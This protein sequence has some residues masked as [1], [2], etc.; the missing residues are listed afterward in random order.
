MSVM[1]G[2]LAQ[3]PMLLRWPAE[4]AIAVTTSLGAAW[5]VA[6]FCRKKSAALRAYLWLLGY[7]AA[8]IWMG[9]R[10][11]GATIPLA[12]LPAEPPPVT[13]S[14]LL[15]P[16]T[17]KPEPALEIVPPPVLRID[18]PDSPRSTEELPDSSI[19]KPSMHIDW[20]RWIGVVWVLGA[21]FVTLRVLAGMGMLAR[22]L[23]AAIPVPAESALAERLAL[24]GSNDDPRLQIRMHSTVP[25][26]VSFG[27]RKWWVLLPMAAEHW[28]ATRLR[29]VLAHERAHCE[30]RDYLAVLLLRLFSAACWF[31]P[32]TWL[33]LRRFRALCENAA[34]DRALEQVEAPIYARELLSIVSELRESASLW[35]AASLSIG[36][37]ATVRQRIAAMLDSARDRRRPTYRTS[38]A[39]SI[40]AI[41]AA[42]LVSGLRLVH[43]ENVPSNTASPASS[44]QSAPKT[45]VRP[46]IKEVVVTVQ[47]DKGAAIAGA[48]IEPSTTYA[49]FPPTQWFDWN[50]AVPRDSVTTDAAGRAVL[51]IPAYASEERATGL[52]DVTVTHPDYCPART[53]IDLAAITPLTLQRGGVIVVRAEAE[54]GWFVCADLDSDHYVFNVK[55]RPKG[56]P[57]SVEGRVPPGQ[58]TIR[59]AALGPDGKR[60]FSEVV[61]LEVREGVNQEI[62]LPLARSTAV[63]GRL[64]ADVPRP[65]R[66]GRVLG[67][68]ARGAAD[69][70]QMPWLCWAPVQPDGTFELTNVPRGH[71]ELVVLCNGYV[72]RNPFWE[73]EGMNDSVR[74][75]RFFF[76][77]ADDIEV[78]MEKTGAG[79][80]TVLTSEGKPLRDAMV[81]IP[82]YQDMGRIGYELGWRYDAGAT[83]LQAQHDQRPGPG[84][85][86]KETL[87]TSQTDVH[88]VATIANLPPGHSQLIVT[89]PGLKMPAAAMPPL[90]RGNLMP[91]KRGETTHVTVRMVEK[92]KAL[93][94][95]EYPSVAA[96]PG[97]EPGATE[98]SLAVTPGRDLRGRVVDENGSPLAGVLVDAWTY[99]PGNETVT[100]LDG[101]FLLKDPKGEEG[102]GIEVQ[103]SLAGFS[104]VYVARQPIGT[105]TKDV[106]LTNRPYFEGVVMDSQGKLLPR[107]LIRATAGQKDNDIGTTEYWCETHSDD[108][109]RYRLHVF[110]DNYRLEIR[111]KSG[112]VARIASQA[113]ARGEVRKLDIKLSPGLTFRA[114]LVD[115][116]SGQPVAGVRLSS[117]WHPGVEG[118]S[119][120]R[121]QIVIPGMFPGRFTFEVEAEKQGYRRW[122]SQAAENVWERR[123]IEESGWQRNFDYLTFTI[124]PEGETFPIKLEKGVTVRGVVHAPNGKGVA[125]ARVTATRTGTGNSMTGDTRFTEL[126]GED[127]SFVILLPA[128]NRV[129]YNLVA[130]DGGYKKWRDFA[131]GVLPPISTKPGQVVEGVEISLTDPCVV[132]GRLV[133][134]AGKPVEG[135]QV[136]AASANGWDHSF[137]LP[138]ALTLADGTFELRHVRP[139]KLLIQAADFAAAQE[140][141]PA[142]MSAEISVGPDRP[143]EGVV[144]TWKP[145]S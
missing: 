2:E 57:N 38:V 118:V 47:D 56:G 31:H 64:S 81:T 121:G 144:L 54:P 25:S 20:A 128:S 109:G 103:F 40:V 136:R 9:M 60:K 26:P 99:E 74:P 7:V 61:P 125:G 111:S 13:S 78:A 88:G 46:A 142:G 65:V 110:P 116:E 106:V 37:R 77:Q 139:G 143:A 113:I 42:V 100:N 76:S 87:W 39:L 97:S 3:W 28:D 107:Q 66:N 6:T 82:A 122:W 114:M 134:E 32:L 53:Q 119:D 24:A 127:G 10:M 50:P 27:L 72:S 44:A 95:I 52:V 67:G 63:R 108:R 91:V 79:T 93:A 141:V 73:P 133:D 18:A 34:D 86:L 23:R 137:Y 84:F 11:G 80:V 115:S 83:M 138:M 90:I 105:L 22:V 101:T 140:D 89:A 48:K 45:A 17:S 135:R 94:P 132:R 123:L 129:S 55:W 85:D 130:H 59:A 112:E 4:L 8:V 62:V 120:D 36:R 92:G 131:N 68:I 51:R 70:T 126:S 15:R 12:L 145:G 71:V 35:S 104:P 21:V 124:T 19:P 58:Y 49:T 102:K 14:A 69:T 43:A 29:L 30:R 16:M 75:Q 98:L 117:Q 5:V 41:L 96:R 1:I 33:G